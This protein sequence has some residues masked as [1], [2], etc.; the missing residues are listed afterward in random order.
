MFDKIDSHQRLRAISSMMGQKWL[1]ILIR[2]IEQPTL[3][4]CIKSK[5]EEIFLLFYDCRTSSFR[6][7][8]RTN[9]FKSI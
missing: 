8:N 2:T 6:E 1:D 5:P 9:C 7:E 3:R 4:T